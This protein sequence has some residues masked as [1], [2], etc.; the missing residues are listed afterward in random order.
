[1]EKIG[2]GGQGILYLA[3]DL[4]LGIYRAVKVL[5]PDQKGE[6]S[7]LKLLEFPYLP[8]MIDYVEQGEYCFLVM[9]YIRGRSLKD[10]LDKG[11]IFTVQ[12]IFDIAGKVLEIL[13]YLHGRKPPVYY[14]DMK[15]ENLML[16][17]EGALYLIDFGSAVLGYERGKYICY[18]TAGYAAPE[19][20]YGKISKASDFFSF[21]KTLLVLC[22]KNRWKYMIQYPGLFFLIWKCCRTKEDK[23]W[24]SGEAALE[25][26]KK[27]RPLSLRIWRGLVFAT[28]IFWIFILCVGSYV[29]KQR[30]LPSLENAVSPVLGIYTSMDFHSGGFGVREQLL[31]QIENAE[32]RLMTCYKKHQEQSRLLLLLAANSE[33]RSNLIQAEAYYQEAA[34][35]QDGGNEGLV[36][37]GLFLCR[38]NRRKDSLE[39]Y[40]K[41]KKESDSETGI[42]ER[43]L[44]EWRSALRNMKDR[45]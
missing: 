41:W 45:T 25:Y 1:M 5:S 6:A 15:P 3:R 14:G 35:I 31:I 4:E 38:Q 16:T 20:Y 34:Q 10:Y 43:N 39:L 40:Q 9:E 32:K 17:E 26:L 36:S 37:Y 42:Q 19:Q 13:I 30:K 22:Q 28:G 2:K 12:E 27:I 18:G 7:I 21:G 33:I 29:G 24:Q 23:R 8:Q 44:R 11:K